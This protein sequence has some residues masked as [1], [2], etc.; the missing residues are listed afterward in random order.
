MTVCR[1]IH[2]SANNTVSLLFLTKYC[3]IV[4]L[5]HIF[6][7]SSVDG[8]LP[9]FPLLDIVNSAAMNNGVDVSFELWFSLCTCPEVV[10]QGHMVVLF[11]VFCI[12]TAHLFLTESKR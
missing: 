7:Y 5:Y 8:N 6:I 4:C 1:S 11:F 3:S 2:V 9:C 10:L 12:P